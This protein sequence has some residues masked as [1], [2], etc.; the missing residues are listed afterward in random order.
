MLLTVVWA[1]GQIGQ[2]SV[3]GPSSI[4]TNNQEAEI[5]KNCDFCFVFES[6]AEIKSLRT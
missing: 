6:E 2:I 3:T 4:E 5:K 1:G